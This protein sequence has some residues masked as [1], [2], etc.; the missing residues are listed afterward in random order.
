MLFSYALFFFLFTT[1]AAA[2]P[3]M[4]LQKRWTT[5][6]VRNL[7]FLVANDGVWTRFE[8]SRLYLIF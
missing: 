3:T 4:A 2:A 5:H 8:V 6:I 7:D 1:F